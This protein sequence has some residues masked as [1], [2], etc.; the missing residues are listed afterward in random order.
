[1]V[2]SVFIFYITKY[3]VLEFSEA[4]HAFFTSSH[5]LR[6][7]LKCKDPSAPCRSSLLLARWRPSPGECRGHPSGACPGH[8]AAP[9]SAGGLA[10]TSCR[11][12][13]F[14][15]LFKSTEVASEMLKKSNHSLAWHSTNRIWSLALFFP[16]CPCL[17]LS[18][19]AGEVRM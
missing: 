14:P 19:A 9:G 11:E 16:L 17:Q 1:M 18:H 13:Q 5:H 6:M 8:P 3:S 10:T 2:L 4:E 7:Q 12:E 15:A